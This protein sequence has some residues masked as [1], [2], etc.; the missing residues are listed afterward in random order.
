[1]SLWQTSDCPNASKAAPINMG[2]W[3]EIILRMGSATG[4][5]RYYVT[6]SLIGPEWSADLL[7]YD[8]LLR[9]EHITQQNKAKTNLML[10]L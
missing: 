10:I 8:N 6:S 4:R 1:M 3:A 7:S 9:V 2:N 5:R